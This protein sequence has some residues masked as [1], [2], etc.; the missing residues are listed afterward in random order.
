MQKIFLL[1]NVYETKEKEKKRK[2][3]Y[4]SYRRTY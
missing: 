1:F 3:T 2:T 4:K